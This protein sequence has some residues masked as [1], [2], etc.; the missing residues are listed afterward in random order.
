MV[1]RRRRGEDSISFDHRGPCTDP[2]RHRS[3]P[4]RWRAEISLGYDANG[5]R[6]KKKTTATSKTVLLDRLKELREDLDAGVEDRAYTL[7]QA[8][9]DWLA[10]GLDGRS[11]KTVRRNRSL[12]YAAANLDELRPEF[13]MQGKLKIRKLG[14]R[15]WMTTTSTPLCRISAAW[16]CLR[17]CR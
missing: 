4:G 3:C 5:R 13:A 2:E 9:D 14:A 1:A 10:E 7:R 6:I 12:F 8:I 11:A 16:E 17:P 15:F